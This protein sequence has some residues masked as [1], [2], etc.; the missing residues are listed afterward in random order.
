[1]K[2]IKEYK[3]TFTLPFREKIPVYI[4]N[5]LQEKNNPSRIIKFYKRYLF[6]LINGQIKF[7]S[8]HI[9]VEHKKILWINLSAPSLGDSLMD[10]SSRILLKDK[11]IDLFTSKKNSTLYDSDEYFSNIFTS[12]DHLKYNTYDLII[13][14][15][16]STRTIAIKN[17]IAK[18]SEFVTMFGFYNGPEINRILFSFNRMNQLLSYKYKK[19]ELDLITKPYLSISDS[20]HNI[21]SKKLP[22]NTFITIVLGGEWEYR[23][24]KY[25]LKVIS[26]IFTED[27]SLNIVLLG[28]MNALSES[29][30][31]LG[32]FEHKRKIF[33]LV[34]KLTFNQTAECIRRARLVMCCDG[35][36]MHAA[37][38]MGTPIL[39]LMARVE[40]RMRFPFNGVK[41]A[42]YSD[43]N[44]N[45]ISPDEVYLKYLS[46]IKDI[47]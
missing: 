17:K 23:T 4:Q 2:L 3:K 29:E 30:K 32:T 37:I 35:G 25:W 13:V 42:I 38:A 19:N 47:S 10:L 5:Y 9:K 14:D 41:R 21:V 28:S 20:D 22:S 26:K 16:Y 6:L 15:S 45:D 31:I 40:P 1:V 18:Y 7:E 33:N 46:L 24:Y 36:L 39:A 44:V 8:E 11:E 27:K 43:A 12:I 34:N